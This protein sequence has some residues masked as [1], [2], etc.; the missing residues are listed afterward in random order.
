MFVINVFSYSV[1][2]LFFIYIGLFKG[3]S[4]GSKNSDSVH[5]R[6][7]DLLCITTKS[8]NKLDN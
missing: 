2:L 3:L 6:L 4:K 1:D 5:Y 7:D 8:N